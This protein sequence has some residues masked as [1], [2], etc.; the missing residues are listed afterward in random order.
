MLTSVVAGSDQVLEVTDR[1][2]VITYYVSTQCRG[3]LYKTWGNA[4]FWLVDEINT[5]FWLVVAPDH[6]CMLLP[7]SDT[8][9]KYFGCCHPLTLS[10]HL[11]KIWGNAGFWLVHTI[12]TNFWLVDTG[13]GTDQYDDQELYQ[14]VS[15]IETGCLTFIRDSVA[16]YDSLCHIVSSKILFNLCFHHLHCN[17]TSKILFHLVITAYIATLH[18]RCSFILSS[19]PTLQHCHTTSIL[20]NL[21]EAGGV[22]ANQELPH[23]VCGGRVP[24]RWHGFYF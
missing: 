21:E 22:Q 14:A 13:G 4:D 10:V 3:Y 8:V 2:I 23:L 1:V 18:P 7:M 12:N 16:I 6:L 9:D 5:H 11:Y 15:V 19:S 17:T 20:F 24:W